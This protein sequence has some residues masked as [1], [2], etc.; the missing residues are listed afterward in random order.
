MI[1]NQPLNFGSK[2]IGKARADAEAQVAKLQVT[3]FGPLV[4]GTKVVEGTNTPAADSMPVSAGMSVEGIRA[5]LENNPTFLT[6]FAEAEFR[7]LREGPGTGPRKGALRLFIEHANAGMHPIAAKAL[8]ERCEKF[9]ASG[10]DE[11]LQALE[12]K[13]QAAK[14][15]THTTLAEA[16]TG[17][18]QPRSTG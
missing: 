3:K 9:L 7:R 18:P 10:E 16:K 1:R 13:A 17:R 12:E 5:V 4:L 8:I 14:T 11:E 2:V 6:P 15:R